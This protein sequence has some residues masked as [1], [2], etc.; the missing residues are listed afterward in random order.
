MWVF[1]KPIQCK[2][3]FDQWMASAFLTMVY[4]LMKHISHRNGTEHYI[5]LVWY[6]K[7]IR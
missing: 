3:S 4:G 2:H 5:I 6:S 7:E 1:I